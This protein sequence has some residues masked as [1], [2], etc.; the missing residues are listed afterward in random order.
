MRHTLLAALLISPLGTL[1]AAKPERVGP[2]T[3]F[4]Q[5][6]LRHTQP[7]PEEHRPQSYPITVT[8]VKRETYMAWLED[9]G[10][11]EHVNEPKRGLVRPTELL[12]VL[13]KLAQTG[14]R[15]WGEACVTMLKDF[16]RAVKAEVA[17]RGWNSESVEQPAVLPS[18]RRLLIG[19]GLLSEPR[20]AGL[21]EMMLDYTRTR[22]VW[23]SPDSFWRGPCHRTQQEGVIRGVVAKWYPDIPEAEAWR[24]YSEQVFADFWEQKDL[25]ENDTGYSMNPTF[26][27]MLAGPEARGSGEFIT[28]LQMMRLGERHLAA[29]TPAGAIN[30]YGPNGGYNS[31]AGYR[32]WMFELIAA[33]TGDGRFRF[34]AHRLMNYLLYPKE[35]I[36]RH[37]GSLVRGT[38]QH[39]AL[40]WLVTDEKAKPVQPSPASQLLH[41]R[42]VW[43]GGEHASMAGA[44][45]IEAL[46][47]T[48]SAS[49]LRCQL[50]KDRVERVVC[51]P[52]GDMIHVAGLATDAHFAYLDLLSG[53][54]RRV[55]VRQATR[56]KLGA[57][58]I[59]P[60]G[61]RR[62]FE[63]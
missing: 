4:M 17:A 32:V 50:D 38:T 45:G 48:P 12:P 3:L 44:D 59:L 9:S 10:L 15:R 36:R 16:H 30:P 22:H 14:E 20:D 5:D 52:G 60:V 27:N 47:D 11:L 46:L 28:H 39:I 31:S 63:K 54:V 7:V 25:T 33:K 26:A 41:R 29:V 62:D 58:E 51:N 24:R 1:H 37:R 55:D 35:P 49:V 8:P 43:L 19:H 61:E 40:A 53:E 6:S 13:P 56:L 34:A 42:Q 23:N 57:E 18:Y 2:P 21:R